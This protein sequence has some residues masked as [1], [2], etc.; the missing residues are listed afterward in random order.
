MTLKFEQSPF[1]GIHVVHIYIQQYA[2]LIPVIYFAETWESWEN[3]QTSTS[4]ANLFTVKVP[5]YAT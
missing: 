3:I 1:F 4:Q 2:P 5:T